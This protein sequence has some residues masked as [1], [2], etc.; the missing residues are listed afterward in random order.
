MLDGALPTVEAPAVTL[1]A[2]VNDGVMLVGPADPMA[3][4]QCAVVA[5]SA[6]EAGIYFVRTA[7]PVTASAPRCAAISDRRWHAA[8]ANATSMT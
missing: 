3:R 2:L 6:R 4:R 5:P 7:F 1:R 8:G